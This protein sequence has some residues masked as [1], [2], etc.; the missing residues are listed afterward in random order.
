[1]SLFAR[2]GQFAYRHRW[3]I[4]LFWAVVLVT[5]ALFAPKLGGQLLIS[6]QTPKP[7]ILAALC[8]RG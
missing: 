1:L 4:L 3:P 7:R 5:A 8:N 6:A 2:L